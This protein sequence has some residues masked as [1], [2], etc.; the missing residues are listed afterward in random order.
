MSD[1]L[2]ATRIDSP[3]LAAGAWIEVWFPA[4]DRFFSGRLVQLQQQEEDECSWTVEF[5]D[6]TVYNMN[7]VNENF[8][9]LAAAKSPHA[10]HLNDQKARLAQLQIG[11]RIQV[12][13]EQPF[14][15]WLSGTIRNIVNGKDGEYLVEYDYKGETWESLFSEQFRLLDTN[16]AATLLA[17][18][19]DEEC[20]GRTNNSIIPNDSHI[21]QLASGTRI[22]VYFDDD[23]GG[24]FYPGTVKSNKPNSKGE[25]K[26]L[27]DDGETL[28]IDLSQEYYKLLANDRS[29]SAPAYE[30]E[31]MENIKEGSKPSDDSHKDK[32]SPRQQQSF[33]DIEN[34]VCI[35]SEE[36]RRATKSK[37]AYM[38]R[39]CVH[40]G[41]SRFAQKAG[42]CFVHGA[43]RPVCQTLG[44]TRVVHTNRLCYRHGTGLL[45]KA[46]R[47]GQSRSGLYIYQAHAKN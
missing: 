11:S 47:M 9:L 29:P 10:K 22:A 6:N 17:Q 28:R 19:E 23:N 46:A 30:S 36:A 34:D 7:L 38:H 26:I 43:K 20:L 45:K 1:S 4:D 40:S 33:H 42:L 18:D 25:T 2:A 14:H 24:N 31:S 35:D 44:C 13:W 5:N 8:R 15:S 37:R 27:F 41:C 39:R 16:T 21:I 3:L 32:E 12:Y